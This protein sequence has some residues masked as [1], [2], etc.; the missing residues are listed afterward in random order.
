MRQTFFVIAWIWILAT[1]FGCNPPVGK[2][3]KNA[4]TVSLNKLDEKEFDK[5]TRE[6]SFKLIADRT[7]KTELLVIMDTNLHRYV[8]SSKGDSKWRTSRGYWI[9]IPKGENESKILSLKTD[10]N[11]INTIEINPIPTVS[12]IGVEGEIVDEKEMKEL[13]SVTDLTLGEHRIPENFKFPYYQVGTPSKLILYQPKAAKIISINPPE[14]ERPKAGTPIIITFD[15]P[16]HVPRYNLTR[17]VEVQFDIR[18]MDIKDYMDRMTGDNLFAWKRLSP[19][20]FQM[21]T[22]LGYRHYYGNFTLKIEWDQPRE[23]SNKWET[24]EQSFHYD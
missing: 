22:P 18:T 11:T 2:V 13:L 4:P 20:T 14:S 15:T 24:T 12:V 8:D 7:P 19:T 6:V 10:L 16:P 23:Y 17:G 3:H 5:F 9:L 21:R 1:F